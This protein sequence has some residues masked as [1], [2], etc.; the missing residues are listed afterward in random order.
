[1]TRPGSL[2]KEY[3][4]HVSCDPAFKPAPAAPGP[5]ATDADREAWFKSAQEYIAAW[6][7]ARE[8]SDY[9]S[10]VL[11]GRTPRKF[12]LGHVKSKAWR[13][14]HDRGK[15][16]AE[17]KQHIGNAVLISLMTRLALRS[18]PALDMKLTHEPDPAWD[19]IEMAPEDII[20]VLDG[21]DPSI[22]GEIG[23][24]VL[25]RLTQ[26]ATPGAGPLF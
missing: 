14:L 2:F 12:V 5:D 18:I 17:S 16:P 26:G 11:D 8:T 9:S 25:R 1:M 20:D 19:G 3:D 6:K 21:Q 24:E 23:Q 10:L 13:S 7:S 15:L 4:F 22:V